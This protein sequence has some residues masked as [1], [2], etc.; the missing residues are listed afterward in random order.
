MRYQEAIRKGIMGMNLRN[1]ALIYP[2]NQRRYYQLADDK[3]KAKHILEQ[4]QLACAETYAIIERIGDI[5]PI[6]ST[7]DRYKKIAIKPANGK[8][9]GGILILKKDSQGQWCK[10]GK[11]VS[12]TYIFQHLANILMGVFSLGSRDRVLIER[13]LE[14]HPFFQEIYPIGV[15]DFRI[16]LLKG[17]ILMGMLRVP[18][19]RSDGKANLHQGGL[20]I[21][22]DLE[23]GVLTYAFDGKRYHTHHPDT[24]R[25]I[26]GKKIPH[27]ETLLQLAID[28]AHAFP[29]DYLGIDIVLDESAGPL[30]MEV[31]VRPG[32]GIQLANKM[33][34]Q[35][36]LSNLY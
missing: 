11:P 13:C 12:N 28:T 16:I 31:N 20:G 7:M 5:A 30:V 18:T 9:G 2:H 34:M 24:D 32:L 19:D 4:A 22:L 15:P 6:W 35:K 25:I 29:L 23:K 21:G 8:G 27:W 3:I 14:P 10:G 26:Q 1:I 17:E 36:T 33:G